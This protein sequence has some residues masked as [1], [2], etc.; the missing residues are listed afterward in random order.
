MAAYSMVSSEEGSQNSPGAHWPGARTLGKVWWTLRRDSMNAD[1]P[2]L[3]ELCLNGDNAAWAELVE[4]YR[5][6]VQSIC[7]LSSISDQDADDLA[8]EAFIR[9]WMNLPSYNPE[10]GGLRSWIASVTRNLRIDRFRRNRQQSLT[11]SMDEGWE[12]SG[13]RPLAEHI[14]DFR[15]T[16]HDSTFTNEV[17]RIISRE[18]NKISPVM[19]DVMI[20]GLVQELDN[21]EIARRLR[22]PEGTVKSRFNRGR[23]QLA[24]L[25]S[26]MRAALDTA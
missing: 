25:L 23:A 1:G 9:I 14:V 13:S 11:D 24:S 16:P 3:V 21:Q 6:L 15:P 5:S 12:D 8:Q 4:E 26:P 10:R 18:T 2:E 7:H 17:R 20:L 22:I 19:R